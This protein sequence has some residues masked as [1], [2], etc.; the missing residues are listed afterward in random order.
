M[1]TTIATSC[2]WSGLHSEAEHGDGWTDEEAYAATDLS[3][4]GFLQAK[5]HGQTYQNFFQKFDQVSAK[6]TE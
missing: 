6:S 3:E 5:I 4:H 2:Y 1:V